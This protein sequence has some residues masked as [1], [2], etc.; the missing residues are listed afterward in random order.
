MTDNLT[1]VWDGT[2]IQPQVGMVTFLAT[3]IESGGALG[4]K[5]DRTLHDA[6]AAR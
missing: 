3:L 5:R 2:Y 6:R 4:R 1:G